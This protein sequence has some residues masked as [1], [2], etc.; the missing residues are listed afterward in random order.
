[1]THT[2]HI[3]RNTLKVLAVIVLLYFMAVHWWFTAPMRALGQERDALLESQRSLQQESSQYSAWQSRLAQLQQSNPRLDEWLLGDAGAVSAQLGQKLD[4]WLSGSPVTCQPLARTPGNAEHGARFQKHTLQ[5]RLLCS[6]Q[7]LVHL[8]GQ[9]E[10]DSPAILI[11]NLE[12]ASR[13]AS[14]DGQ[15][16]GLDVTLDIAVYSRS[17]K[18]VR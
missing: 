13:R 14:G 1:M 6:M 7:G 17:T 2:P 10:S 8:L 11:E 4:G 12:I 3:W 16:A 18:E 5:V 9:I 15:S